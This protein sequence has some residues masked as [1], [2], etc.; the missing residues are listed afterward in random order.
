MAGGPLEGIRI[1]DLTSVVVGPLA[2]QVMADYGAD[3]IK[4]EAPEGDL[5]RNLAGRSVTPGMSGKFLHLN[6][7]K[8]SIAL[9][10]KKP[11]AYAA[12]ARLIAQADVLVW[13]IRP[14]AMARL[15]LSYEDVQKINP[16][17]IYCGMVGFGQGGRY[18]NKVAYDSIIQGSAGIAALNHRALGEPRYLPMVIADR[19]SGLIAVNMILMC[20]IRR[21]RTGTG[22]AIEIPL[23]ENT[24][25]MVLE[26][27]MYLRTFEP[28]LGG[29]CD[30][31][32]VDS[33]AR[34]LPTKDGWICITANTDAQVYVIFEAIG[35][36][37]LK[38]DPRFS[39]L[40]ARFEHIAEFFAIR[41][42]GMKQKTTA[43]WIEIFDRRDV[44]AMPY[45]TLEQ[46]IEDPHLK[47]VGLLK[48]I[49]HPSEGKI[50][51][52]GTPNKLSGGA[53]EDFMQ[54]PQFGQHNAEILREAGYSNAE[55]EELIKAGA[56]IDGRRGSKPSGAA[57][58]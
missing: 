11:Q 27:H 31:R 46:L 41:A 30:P 25:K 24:A 14:A 54:A 12:L 29:T 48:L 23:Y 21:A 38:S 17:I 6:R 36:P 10:I 40:A 19:T 55:I 35:R 22:E 53:R 9:D 15:K 33:E 4:V 5:M 39:T 50:W 16:R 44:P 45:Q 49:D 2:T 52:I 26:E 43:E 13:N 8:R 3:V 7:N 47:D 51:S 34:P 32:L 18:K 20:L 58:S 1:V 42:E 28:P 57:K 56:L 37:E